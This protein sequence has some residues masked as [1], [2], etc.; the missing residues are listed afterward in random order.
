M[1]ESDTIHALFTTLDDNIHARRDTIHYTTQITHTQHENTQKYL[2]QSTF[3]N[4]TTLELHT[5]TKTRNT[6]TLKILV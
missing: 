2:P 6:N 1:P 3:T 5:H 4:S